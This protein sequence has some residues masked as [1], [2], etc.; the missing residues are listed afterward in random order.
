MFFE[1]NAPIRSDDISCF[2]THLPCRSLPVGGEA[3]MKEREVDSANP[4]E[5]TACVK[6]CH[7]DG[8][9]TECSQS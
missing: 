7:E 1:R 5:D 6:G 8:V 4:D 2:F 3:D 9:S